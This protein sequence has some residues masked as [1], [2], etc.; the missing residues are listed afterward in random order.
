MKT[1]AQNLLFFFYARKKK[2]FEIIQPKDIIKKSSNVLI[3]LPEEKELI[4]EI[5][6]LLSIF[7]KVFRQKTFLISK[8]IHQSMNLN[9]EFNSVVYSKEQKNFINLPK[10]EFI[11]FLQLQNFDTIIDCNLR[12]SN[13]HYWLTKSINA[14]LKIGL[15]RKNSTLF[16]NLVMKV[17]NIK[18]VR[19]IYEN[20]LYL[21]KL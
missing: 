17:K 10:K 2:N 21:L 8:E 11:K 4:P 9:G 20:F 3:L 7:N 5:E 14:K 15:Y 1:L 18:N 16:N 13:F 12:D 19:S 6:F